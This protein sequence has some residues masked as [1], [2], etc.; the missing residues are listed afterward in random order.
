[1]KKLSVAVLIILAIASAIVAA[2]YFSKT[3]GTIPHF[4]LGYTKGSNHKHVKHGVAFAGL[5][6]VL[7]LGAWMVSGQSSDGVAPE[8]RTE[9]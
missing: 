8:R 9:E 3:A 7:L 1:M 4:F 6:V 2:I 5:A